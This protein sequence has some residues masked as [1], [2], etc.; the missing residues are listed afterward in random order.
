[1]TC[2][3][4]VISKNNSEV[5]IVSNTTKRIATSLAL[6]LMVGLIVWALGLS[7]L[8]V[9]LASAVVAVVVSEVT[10]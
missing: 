6:S 5:N 10:R 3:V 4:R 7:L 9:G 8:M 2:S 1:M